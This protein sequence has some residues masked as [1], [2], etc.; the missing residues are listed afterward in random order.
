MTS[1]PPEGG[2]EADIESPSTTGWIAQLFEAV[3]Q[4][5]TR[6]GG[7]A[8]PLAEAERAVQ[9]LLT[10]ARERDG[11]LWWAG[12]GGSAAIC[13]HLAQ[14]VMGKLN[15]RSMAFSDAA[16]LTCCANDFGYD[17][18]YVRPLEEMARR[19]DVLIAISSSGNS[20]NILNAVDAARRLGLA[21]VALSGFA[22]DNRLNRAPAEVS[23]HLPSA[24]YGVVEVGHELLLHGI[25][26]TLALREAGA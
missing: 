16:L 2:E 21:V 4:T 10:E 15:L 19:G 13:A 18:V 26:E 12:N 11:A 20:D 17:Q 14:D 8:V 7:K 5:Q 1:P 22:P 24:L 9:R 23:F 6:V 25:I 3:E